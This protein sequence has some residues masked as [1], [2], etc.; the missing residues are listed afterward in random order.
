MSEFTDRD[1]FMATVLPAITEQV[2]LL[3][4]SKSDDENTTIED[5]VDATRVFAP[6]IAACAR[7]IA[8][9]VIEERGL[10]P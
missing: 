8:D 3:I 2:M 5:L 10:Q 7:R 4:R 9:A 1:A 6:E